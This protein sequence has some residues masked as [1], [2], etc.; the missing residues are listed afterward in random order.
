MASPSDVVATS[1]SLHRWR[2]GFK[3]FRFRRIARVSRGDILHAFE[4]PPLCRHALVPFGFRRQVS[5]STQKYPFELL[6]TA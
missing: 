2:L 5:R 4:Y 1:G 3:Q 6:L